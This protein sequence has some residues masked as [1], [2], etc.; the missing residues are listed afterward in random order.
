MQARLKNDTS[1]HLNNYGLSNKKKK[2]KYKDY[3]NNSTVNT[4][5]SNSSY[6]DKQLSFQLKTS[7]LET[8][9]GYCLSKNIEAIDYLKIDVEGAEHLVLEGFSCLLKKQKIRIIQFEYGYINGDTKFLMRDFYQFFNGLDYIVGRVT[10]D[11][12]AFEEFN[13]KINEFKSGP[14]YVAIHSK[15]V[16]IINKIKRK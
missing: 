15:D 11:G 12:V 13:Y 10:K 6:H 2:V 5:F 7:N 4:L 1:I 3:G 8:G 9:D 14:N 16:A